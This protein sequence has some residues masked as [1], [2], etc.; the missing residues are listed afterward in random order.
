MKHDL[1]SDSFYVLNNAE[2]FGKKECIIPASN[3]V[4]N[5][6]L[7]MQKSGYIGSFEFLDNGKQGQFKVQLVGRINKSR[8]IR[9]RF[10]AK[11]DEYEKFESRYLP[12]RGFGILIVSTPKGVMS[13]Q[14]A[15]QQGLGGR[16][17]GYVY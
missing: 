13:H 17:F 11:K 2:K 9:P 14:E 7:V 5:M 15:R 16:I 3:I 8:S 1:L 10:A 6:L 4:K 12:A